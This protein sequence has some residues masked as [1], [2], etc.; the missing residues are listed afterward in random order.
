MYISKKDHKFISIASEAAHNSN[1]MMK[2]GC[3]VVDS[4]RVIGSGCNTL[5]TQF[6][7]RF[8]GTSCSC[9]AEM[10]ALRNA[11][12]TKNKSKAKSTRRGNGHTKFSKRSRRPKSY[13]EQGSYSF[14]G[15]RFPLSLQAV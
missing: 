7:D 6:K 11:F 14:K 9:H 13:V 3:V 10:H 8:I 4:G 2:H 12:K 5:R 1:M 15:M